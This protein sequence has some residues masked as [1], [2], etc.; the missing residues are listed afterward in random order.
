[1][2]LRYITALRAHLPKNIF[3]AAAPGYAPRMGAAHDGSP[4]RTQKA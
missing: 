1:M 2:E 4:S 3:C